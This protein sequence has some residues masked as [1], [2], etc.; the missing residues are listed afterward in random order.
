M[1]RIYIINAPYATDLVNRK[2]R[3]RELITDDM[4]YLRMYKEMK[5]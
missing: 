4:I 2:I 1:Y 5:S 3:D